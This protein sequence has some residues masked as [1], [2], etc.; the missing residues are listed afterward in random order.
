[1]T[2]FII[3]HHSYIDKISLIQFVTY[4]NRNSFAEDSRHD[5]IEMRI[6]EDSTLTFSYQGECL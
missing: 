4:T 2:L 3:L 1:M 6:I 5:H